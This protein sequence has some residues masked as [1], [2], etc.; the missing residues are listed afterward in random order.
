MI[1]IRKVSKSFFLTKHRDDLTFKE[2]FIKS[3]RKLRYRLQN[4][5]VDGPI[6]YPGLLADSNSDL[7]S[8]QV[9]KQV[10]LTIPSGQTVALIGANGCGKSTLLKLLA[11]IYVADEGQIT[12]DGRLSAL[13]E[14]GAGFHPEFSGR[15]NIFVNGQILGLSKR[16]IDKLYEEIVEFSG[17][18][19]FIEMPVRTY[20]SGMFMRLAFSVAVN[21]D[22]DIL[23]IDEI[24]AVGDA[25]F[26]AKCHKKMDEFKRKGKT[27]ILVTHA[28]NLVESWTDRAIYLRDGEIVSDGRPQEVVARYLMDVSPSAAVDIEDS[29]TIF[30]QANK[31]DK[32][33]SP[34]RRDALVGNIE[35]GFD[36]GHELAFTF[37]LNE[38][39]FE[40]RVGL[41]VSTKDSTFVVFEDWRMFEKGTSVFKVKVCISA[42][43]GGEYRFSIVVDN[44]IYMNKELVFYRCV[45]G[46]KNNSNGVVLLPLSID[47]L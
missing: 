28:L 30:L 2:V 20:S 14:L 36:G 37:E 9:L 1:E 31:P 38:S 32:F 46:P 23:L 4:M 11:G 21:V 5:D 16:Q 42:L 29:K 43:S 7:L 26:Q 22:P 13:I 39:Q 6:Q 45:V 19:R 8:N 40:G 3:M 41:R 17:L 47:R 25:E 12:V 18:G 24:L 34:N 15:E 44:A 10:S 33:T 35:L 27:I